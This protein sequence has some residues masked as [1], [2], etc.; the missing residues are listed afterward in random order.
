MLEP[1]DFDVN[2][3][4]KDVPLPP[5]GIGTSAGNKRTGWDAFVRVFKR[6]KP[7]LKKSTSSMVNLE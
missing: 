4:G 1:Q 6:K 2:L 5:V 7:E 3:D